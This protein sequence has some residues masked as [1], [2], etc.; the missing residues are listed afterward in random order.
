MS[1]H[2]ELP[3]NLDDVISTTSVQVVQNVNVDNLKV[4]MKW[5]VD[6]LKSSPQADHSGLPDVAD[7]GQSRPQKGSPQVLMLH[8]YSWANSR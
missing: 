1:V 2:A 3:I 5:V 8:H 7:K 4:F 6:R